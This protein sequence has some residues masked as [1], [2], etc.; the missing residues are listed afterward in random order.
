L[1]AIAAAA[2]TRQISLPNDRIH[3]IQE[4]N[5]RCRQTS[6]LCVEKQTTHTHHSS[7]KVD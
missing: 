2:V 4:N 5:R 6:D 3:L 1:N 7:H